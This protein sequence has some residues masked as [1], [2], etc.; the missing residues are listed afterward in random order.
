MFVSVV[1]CGGFANRIFQMLACYKVAEDTGRKV[2]CNTLRVGGNS[3]EPVEDTMKFLFELFPDVYSIQGI[4]WKSYDC[5]QNDEYEYNH[6]HLTKIPKETSIELIG[7]FQRIEWI[8]KQIPIVAQKI[9]YNTVFLHIRLG[10]YVGSGFDV[11]LQHKYYSDA[12]QYIKEHTKETI[13]FLIFSDNPTKAEEIVKGLLCKDSYTMS[14]A[15]RSLD[16]LREMAACCGGICSNSSLSFLG[17]F[18]QQSHRG[19]VT[20]P[21]VWR[22]PDIL[23]PPIPWAIV[24]DN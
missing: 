3:H 6:P 16:V 2:V 20:V 19:I 11:N 22:K 17:A 8:P 7:W 23:G 1:L 13:H 14:S 4:E 12:I 5:R 18:F 15:K 9:Y 10:D 21:K 24:I